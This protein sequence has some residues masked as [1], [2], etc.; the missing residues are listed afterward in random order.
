MIAAETGPGVSPDFKKPIRHE[1]YYALGVTAFSS[2][3]DEHRPH[4]RKGPPGDPHGT[5]PAWRDTGTP[6]CA[7]ACQQQ[8]QGLST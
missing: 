5:Q 8:I 6:A 7:M 2:H 1:F 4:D 3:I